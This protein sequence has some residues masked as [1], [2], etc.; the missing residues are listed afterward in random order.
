VAA[1]ADGNPERNENASKANHAKGNATRLQPNSP[2]GRYESVDGKKEGDQRDSNFT[3]LLDDALCHA[4]VPCRDDPSV[5]PPDIEDTTH[6]L[7]KFEHEEGEHV[8]VSR[9]M[10]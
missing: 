6:G 7:Q 10:D 4:I 1:G 3:N 2:Q 9:P 5:S 8:D